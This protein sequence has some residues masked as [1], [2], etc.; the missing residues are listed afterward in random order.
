MIRKA[1]K[2]PPRSPDDSASLV[3]EEY[4]MEY[5]KGQL[6]ISSDLFDVSQVTSP[7]I[8]LVDDVVATGG[9]AISAVNLLRSAGA[10]LMEVAVIMELQT[11]DLN[12]RRRLKEEA[13]IDLHSLL[14]V[15]N[16]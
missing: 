1:G 15:A 3:S 12:G 9:T 14:T 2:L 11:P 13:F 4:E 7:R 5:G 10:T 6:Q 16:E 8:L